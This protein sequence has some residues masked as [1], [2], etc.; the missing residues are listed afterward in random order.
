MLD[1]DAWVPLAEIARPHGVKGELRLRPYN[2]DSDLLLGLDEVLVRLPDGEQH[3]VSIDGAR[4]ANDAILMKLYSV[5]DRDRA[6]ELR[7][8]LVCVR[9]RDFPPLED[10]EFYACDV[11][12]AHVVVEGEAGE[13]EIG[14]VRAV[15]SY[16]S[17]DVLVVDPPEG[18][19]AWE[20]PLVGEVVRAVD[21]ASGRVVLATMA[22]VEKE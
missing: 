1:A 21:V 7:G 6:E 3:E 13:C 4:R 16:P 15:R 19:P 12:G 14:K 17:A 5:D 20:V 18:G 8:A 22:G 9:R 2:R 10:G 11:E